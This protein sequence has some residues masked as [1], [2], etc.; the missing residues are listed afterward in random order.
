MTNKLFVGSLVYDM[1]DKQLT[2]IFSVAGTV[3]SAKVI[4]DRDSG[5]SKG[6]GFVEMSTNS[7]AQ[8]AIRDLNNTIQAG[9]TI[10]V[11]EARPKG[12]NGRGGNDGNREKRG[13]W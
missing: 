2:E 13:R 12:K 4:M 8:K 1:D 5:E 6:F 11:S 3:Q 10:M 7:E 9:R